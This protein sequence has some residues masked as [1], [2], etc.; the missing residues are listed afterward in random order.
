MIAVLSLTTLLA[1]NQIVAAFSSDIRV[2][3][4]AAAMLIIIALVH[5]FD[6]TQTFL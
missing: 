2:K 1:R 3:E 4:M 6:G 5:V